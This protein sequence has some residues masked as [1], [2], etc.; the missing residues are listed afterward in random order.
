MAVE[1]YV[2]AAS[3]GLF[4]MFVSE[5]I[6]IFSFMIAPPMQEN[7]EHSIIQQFDPEAK[8][9]QFISIGAA[10]AVILA[11]VSFLMV[12][13]YGSK[14]IGIMIIAGGA[15]LLAGMSY[16][17]TLLD[18]IEPSYLVLAVS[19]TPPLFI[20]VSIPVMVIGILLLK[21]KKRL[22]KEYF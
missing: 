13:R 14:P 6:S 10:P 16:A 15:V 12:K 22:K 21:E 11:A 7:L 4:A 20:S 9:L 1:K 19:I 3:L 2:A 17:F 5:I 18:K 8:I